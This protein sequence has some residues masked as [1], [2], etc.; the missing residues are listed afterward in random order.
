ML[1][2]P[3]ASA[4]ALDGAPPVLKL[5]TKSIDLRPIYGAAEARGAPTTTAE[6]ETSWKDELR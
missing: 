6:R 1:R 3:R 4:D 5:R 2:P